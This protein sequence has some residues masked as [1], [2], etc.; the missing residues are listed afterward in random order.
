MRV[1]FDGTADLFEFL[2]ENHGACRPRKAARFAVQDARRRICP[3]L[4]HPW[5][6]LPEGGLRIGD[7]YEGG[8]TWM[9][10]YQGAEAHGG[11]DINHPAGTPIWAPIAFD[12][13]A[14]FDRVED[15]ANNNRWRGIHR[16]P[17]GS[18]WTLQVH[19]VI[20]L[21]VPEHEPVPAGAHLADGAGVWVGTTEHSHF[22]FKVTE[23]GAAEDEGVLLDPW[24][25]FREMYRDR[26]ATT[27]P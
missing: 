4:L 14:L 25:L 12:D 19:H 16:W 3:V 6:P 15:G 1:W 11:L 9:G 26:K 13:H 18:V 7:C 21:R 17:D 20:G 27:A 5:C 23:P 24:I 2:T 22:V 8:D 10:P